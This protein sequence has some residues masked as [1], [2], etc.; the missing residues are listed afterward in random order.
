MKPDIHPLLTFP[1][2]FLLWYISL[3]ALGFTLELG[4]C[5]GCLKSS[6]PAR[7][8]LNKIRPPSGSLNLHSFQGQILLS[9]CIDLICIQIAP[10]FG[11]VFPLE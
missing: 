2:T 5:N 6:C 7:D 10:N 9:Y 11:G 1:T 4:D 3:L 8:W